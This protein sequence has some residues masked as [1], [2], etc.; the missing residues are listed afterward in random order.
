MK[1]NSLQNL[2]EILTE[3]SEEKRRK[4][5]DKV[6]VSDLKNMVDRPD[7]VAEEDTTAPDPQLLVFMKAYRNTVTVPRHWS[8]KRKYLF[9]F[10]VT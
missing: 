9:N 4:K 8:S 10:I 5:R 7:V 1:L 6:L 2:I 3:K